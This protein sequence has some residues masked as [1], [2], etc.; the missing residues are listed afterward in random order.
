MAQRLNISIGDRSGR[1]VVV[2]FTHRS[3]QY[4]LVCQCDCGTES[5]VVM[6]RDFLR[7]TRSCGCLRRE[8]LLRHGHGSRAAGYHPLYR[9]W[10]G[11]R[12]RCS[13][14]RHVEWERYGGRGIHVCARWSDFAAFL[15]DMG[16]RPEGMTLD[17]IDV[18]GNYEPGNVRWAT[19]QEQYANQREKVTI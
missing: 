10:M 15:A 3:R 2:G 8:Q 11:M 17:R 7:S 18:D 16:E 4:A 1:L 13:N 9:T 12:E 5:V 14:P 6:P 19:A